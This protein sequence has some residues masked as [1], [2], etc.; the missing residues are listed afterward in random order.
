MN[1]AQD[2][3]LMPIQILEPETDLERQLLSDQRMLEGLDWGKPRF[4]HPE[5]KVLFHIREVLDNIDRIPTYPEQ[6]QK[7]RLAALVHDTFKY[8]EAIF[9]SPR[10]WEQNH[11]HL[12][13]K[14]LSE[15]VDDES[16]LRLVE[17]HDEAYYVWRS[18]FLEQYQARGKERLKQFKNLFQDQMQEYYLFFKCD[19]RTGDKNQA[20]LVWFESSM[21]GINLIPL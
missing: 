11:A 10:S 21:E 17:H 14:F 4:G 6:R 16:L 7:L 3:T 1:R 18:L 9:P 12:A 8:Q 19:T 15:F 2:K 20:P 13:R 5:G